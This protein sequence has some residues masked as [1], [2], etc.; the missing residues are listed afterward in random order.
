VNY[1]IASVDFLS[2]H[3]DK[4]IAFF[5]FK[6]S[7]YFVDDGVSAAG[8][9]QV[10]VIKRYVSS[11]DIPDIYGIFQNDT[12]FLAGLSRNAADVEGTHGKL[13]TRLA[14]GLRRDCSD[15]LSDFDRAVCGKVTPV[16]FLADAVLRLAG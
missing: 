9:E 3:S 2:V 12:A 13:R 11:G 6:F 16:T 10:A 8:K 4:I 7:H 1:Y 15:R 5:N 14:D